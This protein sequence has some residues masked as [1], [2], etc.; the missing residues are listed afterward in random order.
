MDWKPDP[1]EGY[2]PTLSN[3]PQL[4]NASYGNCSFN[5]TISE[6]KSVVMYQDVDVDDYTVFLDSDEAEYKF[7]AEV[8]CVNRGF[9]VGVKFFDVKFAYLNASCKNFS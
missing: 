1:A 7:S 6:H 2:F 9:V 5:F 8:R 3:Y 4:E